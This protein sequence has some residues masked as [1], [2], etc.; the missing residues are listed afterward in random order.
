MTCRDFAFSNQNRTIYLIMI[1]PNRGDTMKTNWLRHFIITFLCLFFLGC[2]ETK[3]NYVINPDG[4]G[5]VLV[6]VKTASMMDTDQ[7]NAGSSL[8]KDVLKNAAGIDTWKDIEFKKLEDGKNYFK[9][10]AYFKDINMVRFKNI[11]MMDSVSFHKD[12]KNNLVIE[13]N[14]EDKSGPKAETK[15][16]LSKEDL[17]KAVGEQKAQFQQMKPMMAAFLGTMKT[18]I[19]FQLPGKIEKM[20]N[21]KKNKDGILSISFAGQKFLDAFDK[22]MADES[23]WRQQV[24]SGSDMQKRPP[25]G[26]EVNEQLF[27]EKGP[28]RATFK[29]KFETFFDYTKEMTDAQA[30]YDVMIAALG[31]A[32][33]VIKPAEKIENFKGGNFTGV[34]IVRTTMSDM[35][36]PEYTLFGSDQTYRISIMAELPGAL[37]SA[38]KAVAL[39]ATADN[40][41]DLLQADEWSRETSYVQLSQ[42]K[43]VVL[44]DISLLLPNEKVNGIRELSGFFYGSTTTG[45][46]WIETGITEFKEGARGTSLD[47]AVES[48]KQSGTGYE[49]NLKFTVSCSLIKDIQILDGT[50]KILEAQKYSSSDFGDGCTMGL[51]LEGEFP[52]KGTI[53]VELYEDIQKLEIPFSITNVTLFG[54]P[55]K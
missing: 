10:T 3:L 28:V 38:D 2:Y 7:P 32:E 33:E 12:G 29:G 43:S 37:L 36:D 27:G 23:W 16:A 4:S 22:L 24:L 55:V 25:S 20:N 11:S 45:T 34:R 6:E 41:D 50:G 39:K 35:V 54:K 8:A 21:F 49:M 31:L 18:E 26:F 19:T 13:L 40:G 42:N 30:N 51:Y 5:K 47:V 44:W 48:I 1:K 53:R 46:K 14:H 15:S 52:P 9:G 17:D